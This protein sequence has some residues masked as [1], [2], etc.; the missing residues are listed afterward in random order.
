M[1]VGWI[2]HP[3]PMRFIFAIT[4]HGEMWQTVVLLVASGTLALTAFIYLMA[5]DRWAVAKLLPFVAFVFFLHMFHTTGLEGES[6]FL[7]IGWPWYAPL[8]CLVMLTASQLLCG[9][10]APVARTQ[11]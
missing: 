5:R 11:S 10:K 8:G 3:L 2:S 1:A 7:K 4:R 6:A 9:P